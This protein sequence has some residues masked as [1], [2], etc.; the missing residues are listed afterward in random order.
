M[1]QRTLVF[2]LVAVAAVAGAYVLGRLHTAPDGRATAVAPAPS[3]SLDPPRAR[4][5]TERPAPLP[6][7]GV[8]APAAGSP[9]LGSVDFVH[10]QVTNSN[11]KALLADGDLLWIGSSRGVIRYETLTGQHTRFDNRNG[12]LSNGVFY[13]G[14]IR[15]EVWVGTYG[16]GLSVKDARTGKWRNYNVPNGMGDAF[17][18]HA[19]EASNGDIWIATWSGVNRVVRGE[20]DKIENWDLYTVEN[21]KGGLPNDWVYRLA[22]GRNGDIWL[23][24]EGGVARFAGG[25]W[26]NWNHATGIGAPYE[27]VKADITFRSDPG[28]VS[29]HHAMQKQE[30]GLGDVDI[31]YNPNYIVSL[32]VADDGRI[33]AGTW[34]AGLS[35]FDGARWQTL[36]QRDG[37]P[38]NHVFMLEK[39]RDGVIWI[40]TSRGLARHD[41]QRFVHYGREHGLFSDNVFSMA[42]TDDGDAWVGSFGGLTQYPRGLKRITPAAAK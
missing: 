10:F 24:T 34:G 14:K 30:Q 12:L 27:S 21:T 2:G 15:G 37:L 25:A 5:A 26:T 22:E 23:A 42:F 13:L 4:L 20:M 7:G 11:V 29:S 35:V 8:V 41:G 16:G 1:N 38:S 6:D 33:W 40:G 31:A 36:T 39:D 18:Y 19:L 28:Q 17:V 3:P 9:H 32:V